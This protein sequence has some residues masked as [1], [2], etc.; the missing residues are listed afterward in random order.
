L[1]K[2][3]IFAWLKVARDKDDTL[4]K[5]SKISQL[6]QPGHDIFKGRTL[7]NRCL[8]IF[9]LMQINNSKTLQPDKDKHTAGEYPCA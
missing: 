3:T 1:G 5:C 6:L 9:L 2:K 8:P 7:P 4:A